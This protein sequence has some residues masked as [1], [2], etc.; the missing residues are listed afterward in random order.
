VLRRAGEWSRGAY[1]KSL[2]EV[3]RVPLIVFYDELAGSPVGI[4]HVSYERDTVTLYPFGGCDC[5]AG[6]E[7]EM[8]VI[9]VV[10]DLD[11]RVFAVD[12]LEVKELIAGADTG[13]EIL[14]LEVENQADFFGIELDRLVKVRGS[15]LRDGAGY[16]HE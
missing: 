10:D 12:E 2:A 9:A 11:R 7:V 5:V 16:G 4:V 3:Q 8:E 1:L 14:E 6:F 13:V 15:Q